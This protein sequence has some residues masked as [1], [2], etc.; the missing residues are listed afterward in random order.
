LQVRVSDTEVATAEECGDALRGGL[1]IELIQLPDGGRGVERLL[2]GLPKESKITMVCPRPSW[3]F[4][5]R[6][7][8]PY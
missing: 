3:P 1:G 2:V 6:A 7:G 5:Y 8:K 4:L